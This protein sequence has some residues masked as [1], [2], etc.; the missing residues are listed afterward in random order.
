MAVVLGLYTATATVSFSPA[1]TSQM[2][3]AAG[4]VPAVLPH[5]LK[6]RNTSGKRGLLHRRVTAKLP[7][8]NTRDDSAEG[9]DN[10][11][12][13]LPRRQ[14]L[15]A[16]ASCLAALSLTGGIPPASAA[17]LEADDDI[18]LLEKVKKDRKKRLER[19]GVISSS[20]RE[21]GYL[22]ELVYKL[23]KVGQAI[24]GNDL[25]AAGTILGP[26]A[27]ADWM[28]N[29]NAA[30]AKLS[31]SSEEKNEVHAFNSSLASLITSVAKMDAESSKEAFVTS[32]NAL[33]KW[34]TL[35]GL[36]GEISGL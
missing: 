28:K 10:R 6:P 2:S 19:Q 24:D 14:Y 23:S 9:A 35:A 30:F 20:S 8:V 22:Q 16:A 34:V 27:N 1:S 33:E 18:E 11:P 13:P 12:V 26:N 15:A 32:A 3:A 17:I 7:A 31:S 36:V 25:S 5:R 21:T 4:T 29:A